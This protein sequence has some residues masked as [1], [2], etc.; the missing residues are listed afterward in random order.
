MYEG[1]LFVRRHGLKH[2]LS[3]GCVIPF[4]S[5]EHFGVSCEPWV[6]VITESVPF[7][8]FNPGH[9]HADGLGVR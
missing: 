3:F 1:A 7:G 5:L 2:T 9:F 8:E 4:R 6:E